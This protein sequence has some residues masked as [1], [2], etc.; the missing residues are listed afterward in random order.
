M[1]ELTPLFMDISSVYSGDELGLPYRDLA[2]EGI[3]DAGSLAVTEKAGGANLSVDVAAGAAWVLGDTNPNAQPCYRVR[4]D[5]VVNLGISPDPSNPRKVLIV[6]QITDETFAGTGRNWQLI[7]I[8][9]TPAASPAEPALPASALPLA[10][11]DVP[12]ADTSITNSQITDRRVRAVAGGTLGAG[13]TYVPVWGSTGGAPGLGNGTITGRYAQ[14]GKLVFV[15]I[16]LA[17]GSTTTYGAAAWTFT[18]PVACQASVFPSVGYRAID[19]STGQQ[20]PGAGYIE[21]TNGVVPQSPSLPINFLGPT[22]PFT[23]AAGDS[24]EIVGT[25]EAA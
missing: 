3:V 22:I 8:H 16:S 17:M 23:W 25:Y 19:V 9:G 11:I 18:L 14:A 20:Y 7:A 15:Q 10:M 6:A 4:N 24:V 13:R 5:A 2:S 1:A 12:A 21:P